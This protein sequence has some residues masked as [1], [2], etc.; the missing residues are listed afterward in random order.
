MVWPQFKIVK[1]QNI[2]YQLFICLLS[3][4]DTNTA[5]FRKYQIVIYSGEIVCYARRNDAVRC[6]FLNQSLLHNSYAWGNY[7]E[8]GWLGII[9]VF[10]YHFK[11]CL[12]AFFKLS[13]MKLFLF[14]TT[15]LSKQPEN[16]EFKIELGIA[17]EDLQ[18]S[19]RIK[20]V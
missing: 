19:R 6:H 15:A 5:C 7:C 3:Y 4:Y 9:L 16:S 12:R 13:W 11:W 17:R 1:Q 2:I 20:E 10:I 8:N 14:S 18:K